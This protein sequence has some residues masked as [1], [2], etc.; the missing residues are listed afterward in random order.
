MAWTTDQE[1]AIN[2]RGGKILVSA[3]AGSGKTAVLSE[4][5]LN[6][7]LSGGDITRLLVVTFTNKAAEE[8]KDRIKSKIQKE[9][10]KDT[11]NNHLKKQLTL[12]NASKI[13]TMDSFYN[14]IVK[15]NFEKLDIMPSFSIMSGSE[16][17]ILKDKVLTSLFDNYLDDESFIN[18]LHLFN[19]TDKDLIKDEVLFISDYLESIPFFDE[20]TNN[21][22]DM[23]KTSYFKDMFFDELKSRFSSYKNLYKDIKEEIY[24]DENLMK[25]EN[26]INEEEKVINT[27]LN[28]NNLDEL[29]LFLKSF[30]FS[31]QARVPGYKDDYIFNKYKKIRSTLKDDVTKRLKVF[32]SINE[33]YLNNENKLMYKSLS[34]LFDLIKEFKEELL[35]EKKRI[36]K[37]SFSDIS[38]FVTILLYKNGK[39]TKLAED[40]SKLYDEILIDEYQ[41]T[42]KMQSIIFSLIS[43]NN[44]N[45][46]MVGDIK[47][48][49]YRFRSADVSIFNDD[50]KNS[51]KDNFPMLITLSKNFR[52]N[53]L[54]LDFCNFIFE[55]IM[56]N[57]IGEVN[58]NEDE[59]LYLGASYPKKE[60]DAEIIL[61]DTKDKE[62]DDTSNY[63]KEAAFVSEKIKNLLDS[64]YKVYD[65]NINSYRNIKKSDIAILFRSLSNSDIYVKEL[66]KNNISS[67]VDKD[68]TF[69][70]N[71]DVLLIISLFKVIDNF[72]DDVS[73]MAVLKSKIFNIS[74]E[75]IVNERISTKNCYLY[76]SLKQSDN[77]KIINALNLLEELR[78]YTITNNIT[79]SINYI[80]KKLDIIN[81]L[82]NN[83]NK[84]K[85]LFMMIKNASDF[86]SGEVKTFH[87]FVFLIDELLN[88]ESSFKGANPVEDSDNILITTIHKSKG[89]EYPV[90][91]LCEAGKK[92]NTDD[93][94]NNI[95]ID[96]NYGISFDIFNYE[97]NYKYEPLSK[98]VLK[99]KL[100]ILMLSEELRVLYV[101]LTR[102]KEKI[103]ITGTCSNLDKKA[104]DASYIVG[105]DKLLSDI[106]IKGCSSYLDFILGVIIRHP[107]IKKIYDIN[108]VIPY[109]NSFKLDI[110]NVNDIIIKDEE[111]ESNYSLTKIN[112]VTNYVQK[113]VYENKSVSM[114]KSDL[115]NNYIKKPYFLNS[116]V[117]KNKIGTLYH[118]LFEVLPINSYNIKEIENE[119]NKL[120]IRNV[121]RE[122]DLK[123][124]DINKLY[125]FYS[126]DIYYMLIN[127]SEVFK[128]KEINFKTKIDDKNVIITGIID[129]LFKYDNC[130]YIIDYKTDD[131]D[132]VNELISRYSIQLDLYENA[133][134]EKYN[135]KK[136]KK[137][138]Y[139][140]KF[141]KFI[142]V[143]G[144]ND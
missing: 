105:K 101:A 20:Y 46:F 138:I 59:A 64:G 50:K 94:K 79:S 112:K 124:I 62:D 120:I 52:S 28:I 13:T 122:D 143:G 17:K 40:I 75:E 104:L 37:Y 15:Q 8:M 78:C 16:E 123:Y 130:Y 134:K 65:K 29:S 53:S 132:N 127:S 140:V 33:S 5:V 19:A 133:I 7:V 58:Y 25:L 86:E 67:Y 100:K 108:D 39:K 32:K 22:K 18:L 106:Y 84:L 113:D 30:S 72:Y 129:L 139:S 126:S 68:V 109:E 115:N 24:K 93:L 118:K 83:K 81:V 98:I 47:Q 103:I 14:E 41:D 6:F 136:V 70:D 69:F 114:I 38:Y 10:E 144:S 12:I 56:S 49:I 21:I 74:E 36:N 89:L 137:Y 107:N 26:N 45:L 77:D 31:T 55:S 63:E 95:I 48:S 35:K 85:N 82:A 87:D 1:K 90:V 111:K 92:F 97:K 110:I 44:S 3:A 119:I 61:I 121:I 60:D 102:A 23:Y 80:Y 4:R 9:Y 135:A 116:S 54:V 27:I 43:N 88:N 91:F 76:D 128:E 66:G 34:T 117:K 96:S 141:N 71:N 11:S 131:V 99:D 142:L 2:T 57:E 125:N 73:L 51:F 42:N